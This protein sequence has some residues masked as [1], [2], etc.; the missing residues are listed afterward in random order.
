MRN[1]SLTAGVETPVMMSGKMNKLEKLLPKL[2]RPMLMVKLPMVMLHQPNLLSQ[3]S[4]PNPLMITLP[5]KPRSDFRFL[6]RLLPLARLTKVPLT[7][8]GLAPLKSPV[9]KKPTSSLV[10]LGKSHVNV[11]RRRRTPS[12]LTEKLCVLKTSLPN[13]VAAV[14]V[15]EVIAEIAAVVDAVIVETVETA[16]TVQNVETDLLV[17]AD[18]AVDAAKE[19]A[20]VEKEVS[21]DAE[22]AIVANAVEAAPVLVDSAVAVA[23]AAMLPTWQI[24]VLSL[25]WAA[26][27]KRMLRWVIVILLAM[28]KP[29]KINKSRLRIG[30][31]EITWTVVCGDHRF[32]QCV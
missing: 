7:R 3:K 15:A 16:E 26:L 30:E 25:A 31:R 29:I 22:P 19:L 23:V 5:K 2:T 4:L 28:L 10:P 17:K 13:V 24:P 9:K 14:E 18:S 12:N 20:A 8:N 1:K 21:V 6:V 11:P 27:R 32:W